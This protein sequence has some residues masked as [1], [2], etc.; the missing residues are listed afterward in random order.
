MDLVYCLD[1]VAFPVTHDLV[2][3]VNESESLDRGK[4][5]L[6]NFLNSPSLFFVDCSD[7]RER[8]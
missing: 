7:Y 2:K 5:K 4:E 1:T 8:A 6:P 3:T